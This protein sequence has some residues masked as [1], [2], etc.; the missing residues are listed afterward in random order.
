M[1]K[2]ILSALLIAL[3]AITLSA[4]F[5]SCKK[6]AEDATEPA[7]AEQPAEGDTAA[8]APEGGDAPKE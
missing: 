7:V 3:F 1:R 2:N 5:I 4:T 6:Q 8:P